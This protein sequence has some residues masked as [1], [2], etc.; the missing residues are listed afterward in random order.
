[1]MDEKVTFVVGDFLKYI[2]IKLQN[3]RYDTQLILVSTIKGSHGR[4]KES[5]S[6]KSQISIDDKNT[7][8]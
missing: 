8:Y 2:K 6:S 5:Y 7:H 4:K 1:M 3:T